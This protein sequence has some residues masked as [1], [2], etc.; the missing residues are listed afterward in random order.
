MKYKCYFYKKIVEE[1]WQILNSKFN[2]FIRL[3][4][5]EQS[6]ILVF[7]ILY[8]P[9]PEKENLQQKFCTFRN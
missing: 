8:F 2:Q 4:Q 9:F 3:F 6:V 1:L 7:G 5:P